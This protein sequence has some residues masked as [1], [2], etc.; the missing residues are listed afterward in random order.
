MAYNSST[1]KDEKMRFVPLC[2][3]RREA[4]KSLLC[5]YTKCSYF[6]VFRPRVKKCQNFKFFSRFLGVTIIVRDN[7][8]IKKNCFE[9]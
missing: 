8:K 1:I 7:K 6:W 2:R 9:I 3:F 4:I 5:V